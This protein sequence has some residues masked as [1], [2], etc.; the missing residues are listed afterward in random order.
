M[1]AKNRY[2]CKCNFKQQSICFV[3][4]LTFFV[5]TVHILHCTVSLTEI[6]KIA[7]CQLLTVISKHSVYINATNGQGQW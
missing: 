6:S 5:F 3:F 2:T 7:N 1:V 4:K